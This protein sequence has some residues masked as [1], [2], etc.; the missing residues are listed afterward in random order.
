VCDVAWP[1]CFALSQ[2]QR[3]QIRVERDIRTLVSVITR[4]PWLLTAMEMRCAWASFLWSAAQG[5][6]V[7]AGRK[8]DHTTPP[9]FLQPPALRSA[10]SRP[11]AHSLQKVVRPRC[12]GPARVVGAAAALLGALQVLLDACLWG[13]K[14]WCV[15][16]AR[17]VLRCGVGA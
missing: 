10:P 3:E 15:A 9:C 8:T 6:R 2:L 16:C 1:P 11:F 4:V 7:V 5:S 13:V 12:A 14:V 17:V